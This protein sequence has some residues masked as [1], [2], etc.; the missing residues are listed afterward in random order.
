MRVKGEGNNER[1]G[2]GVR[3]EVQGVTGSANTGSACPI[4]LRIV[5]S[6][7]FSSSSRMMS[8]CPA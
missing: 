1:E 6:A 8:G 7:F 5:A 3:D 2:C 4:R